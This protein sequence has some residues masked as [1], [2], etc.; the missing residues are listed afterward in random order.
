M[1]RRGWSP[2]RTAGRMWAGCCGIDAGGKA[3]ECARARRPGI[4]AALNYRLLRHMAHQLQI[5]TASLPATTDG[6][7]VVYVNEEE[8]PKGAAADIWKATGLD[9]SAATTAA[10]FRGKQGHVLDIIAP[11]GLRASRLL[12]LGAGK[13]SGNGDTAAA[14]TD[15]GGSLA[16]KLPA[17]KISKAAVLLEGDDVTPELVADLAAGLRLRHYRFDRYKTR[18]AD[19]DENEPRKLTV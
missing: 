5:R 12:V 1:A 16:G 3:P 15:R 6:T 11:A 13:R 7:L 9:W 18:K 17:L 14:W 2:G 19:G 8:G 10:S 4:P